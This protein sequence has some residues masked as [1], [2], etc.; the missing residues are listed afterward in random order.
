LISAALTRKERLLNESIR[1][2]FEFF[3]WPS[4]GSLPRGYQEKAGVEP[5]AR[6]VCDYIAGMRTFSIYEADAII[7]APSDRGSVSVLC[8]AVVQRI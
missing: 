7:A 1:E 8:S 5:L 6:V 3:G 4:R 2:R